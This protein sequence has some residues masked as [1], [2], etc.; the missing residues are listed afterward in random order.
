MTHEDSFDKT[1]WDPV[2]KEQAFED[3]YHGSEAIIQLL[4]TLP[5]PLEDGSYWVF[6]ASSFVG[7]C[8]FD[9]KGKPF[10]KLT[11]T[12][13]PMESLRFV[14]QI[15][16]WNVRINSGDIPEDYPDN[17]AGFFDFTVAPY[18]VLDKNTL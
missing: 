15:Q 5:M 13:N 1:V 3:F 9:C 11:T 7:T 2:D 17:P 10:I 12:F 16:K 8:S 6:G 4:S 18:I 14:T